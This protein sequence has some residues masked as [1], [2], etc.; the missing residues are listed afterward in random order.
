MLRTEQG[1][2]L[3]YHFDSLGEFTRFLDDNKRPHSA[4]AK[5]KGDEFSYYTTFDEAI[6]LAQT[7]WKEG[8]QDLSLKSDKIASIVSDEIKSYRWDVTGLFFDVG[9]MLTG[10]PDHWMEADP[11]TVPRIHKICFNIAKS[12]GVSTEQI[13]N[14]GASVAALV[15][16]IQSRGDIVDFRIAQ[17]VDDLGDDDIHSTTLIDIDTRPLDMDTIAFVSAHPAMLRRLIFI[18]DEIAVNEDD[19]H[20]YG[21]PADLYEEEQKE[22]SLYIGTRPAGDGMPQFNTLESSAK[23]VIEQIEKVYKDQA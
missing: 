12:G 21:R 19:C 16:S 10:S 23:W 3:T 14:L 18:M 5:K 17:V 20:G 4:Y 22:Y 8:L 1:K 7:G 15:D 11:D 9:E 13:R 6:K 2:N